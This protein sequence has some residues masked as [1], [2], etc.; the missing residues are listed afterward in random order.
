MSVVCGGPS[1]VPHKVASSASP[2]ARRHAQKVPGRRLAALQADS[3]RSAEF[4]ELSHMLS[5]GI[6]TFK[7]QVADVLKELKRDRQ[8]TKAMQL[9]TDKKIDQLGDDVR[10]VQQQAAA[11]GT[12]LGADNEDRI[13]D[14]LRA[15]FGEAAVRGATL[16]SG[17]SIIQRFEQPLVSYGL[18][19]DVAAE[20]L[21][22]GLCKVAACRH[23]STPCCA[24]SSAKMP[25][26]PCCE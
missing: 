14:S 12:L 24:A 26:T 3:F 15:Q 5:M 2:A 17:I 11:N 19:A 9:L 6:E 10:D 16:C 4:R 23:F 7:G 22:Q 25:M 20:K 21:V 1:F 13:A 18:T 8:Q